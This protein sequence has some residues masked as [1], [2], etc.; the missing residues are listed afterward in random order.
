MRFSLANAIPSTT[1]RVPERFMLADMQH[2]NPPETRQPLAAR[3]FDDSLSHIGAVSQQMKDLLDF[4]P[5]EIAGSA[6]VHYGQGFTTA[7]ADPVR[8]EDVL[9]DDPFRDVPEEQSEVVARDKRL[10]DDIQIKLDNTVNNAVGAYLLEIGQVGFISDNPEGPVAKPAI[11]LGRQIARA[12]QPHLSE[13]E[14]K[15]PRLSP[16]SQALKGWVEVYAYR[17]ALGGLEFKGGGEDIV[18]W[19]RKEAAQTDAHADHPER[20][21]SLQAGYRG[22]LKSK[23]GGT[24]RRQAP[25]PAYPDREDMQNYAPCGQDVL[26]HEFNRQMKKYATISV[27]PHPDNCRGNQYTHIA[28]GIGRIFAH[29][30]WQLTKFT[31]DTVRNVPRDVQLPTGRDTWRR[32]CGPD[33]IVTKNVSFWDWSSHGV[34][35]CPPY[36]SR[37]AKWREQLKEAM[38]TNFQTM[39]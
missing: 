35:V 24:P 22:G 31:V 4:L 37:L 17:L 14:R 19:A 9:L 1:A 3:V 7:T 34:P 12:I 27:R 39:V 5:G 11:A 30:P 15:L 20:E 25:L 2:S 18:E 32:N 38:E 26:L 23:R 13:I 36:V 8:R 6:D 29:T 16:F 28:Y 33:N 21:R 10:E